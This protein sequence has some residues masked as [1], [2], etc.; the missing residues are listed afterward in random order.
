RSID[1]KWSLF[2]NEKE[3]EKCKNVVSFCKAKF[4]RT[5]QGQLYF[6][7]YMQ[8]NSR[9]TMN[10]VKAIFDDDEGISFLPGILLKGNSKENLDY[11]EKLYGRYKIYHNPSKKYYKCNFFDLNNVKECEI[12]TIKCCRQQRKEQLD[13]EGFGP[14]QFEKYRFLFGSSNETVDKINNI[15]LENYKKQKT[16]IDNNY[17]YKDQKMFHYKQE[18]LTSLQN[19]IIETKYQTSEDETSNKRKVL[20][21]KIEKKTKT[22]KTRCLNYKKHEIKCSPSIENPNICKFCFKKNLSVQDCIKI[23]PSCYKEEIKNLNKLLNETK[24]KNLELEK[25]IST[26]K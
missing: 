8:F 3:Y 10:I 18:F 12:C 26:L 15:V 22:A 14:F 6:H 2:R 11:V 4:E 16:I 25:Q 9:A 1:C 24:L 23:K 17:S 21:S 7:N 20:K 5:Q 13:E 19:N